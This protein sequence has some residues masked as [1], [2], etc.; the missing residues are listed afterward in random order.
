MEIEDDTVAVRICQFTS[1]YDFGFVKQWP[2]R[3]AYVQISFT[4][5]S[6]CVCL[7]VF[8]VGSLWEQLISVMSYTMCVA[9]VRSQC[10]I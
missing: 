7:N 4:R 5:R 3:G 9:A 6:C 2:V 8:Y 10:A 1:A